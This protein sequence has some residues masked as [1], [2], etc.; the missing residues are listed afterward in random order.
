MHSGWR[1]S[2]N[3]HR[4][5][6]L[7]IVQ[8]CVSTS[9]SFLALC[10]CV[11]VCVRHECRYFIVAYKEGLVCRCKQE[12]TAKICLGVNGPS[13]LI[14]SPQS[15][16]TIIVMNC[17]PPHPPPPQFVGGPANAGDFGL[18]SSEEEGCTGEFP[19][20]PRQM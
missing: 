7:D 16:D 1:G 20:S 13:D 12:V 18:G 10:V 2:L 9:R 4:V 8:H 3:C 15:A 6:E 11:C 5:E 19:L 14:V 17:L